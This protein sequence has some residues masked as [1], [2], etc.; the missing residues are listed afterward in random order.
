MATDIIPTREWRRLRVCWGWWWRTALMMGLGAVTA[1]A[2]WAALTGVGLVL[3]VV[4][5]ATGP[6]TREWSTNVA[7]QIEAFAGG[8]ALLLSPGVLVAAVLGLALGAAA[9]SPAR[10]RWLVL[11][12]A[13]IA[14][15]A[16]LP[17]IACL[18]GL[19]AGFAEMPQGFLAGWAS[20]FALMVWPFV[21]LFS[22]PGVFGLSALGRR[23]RGG[24]SRHRP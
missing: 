24:G 21:I 1:A 20:V 17:A 13:T 3:L 11:G 6:V 15:I 9:L 10:R 12:S 23:L 8:G 4:F 16:P 18:L 14:A 5:Y 7:G 19:P 22:T 2:P